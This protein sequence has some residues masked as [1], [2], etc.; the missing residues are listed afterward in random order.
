MHPY[1]ENITTLLSDFDERWAFCGGW[2]IDLVLNRIT[3]EHKDV[4]MMLFREQQLVMQKYLF[5]RGWKLKYAHGGQLFRWKDGEF[6]ELPIHTIWCK[7]ESHTPDFLEILL[8]EKDENHFVFRRDA[9]IQ[10]DLG[11]TFVETL[12]GLIALA[13]EIV[14][15][16]KSNNLA[17]ADNQHDF[18]VGIKILSE[19]QRLWLYNALRILYGEHEW[20]ERL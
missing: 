9:R 3:R 14:L 10:R 4:D 6:L 2:A 19:E 5:E 11:K 17:H 16:Y 13:P 12:S 8:N 7:H 1:L 18:T 15:L 20:R